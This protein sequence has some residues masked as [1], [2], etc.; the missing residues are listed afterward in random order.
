MNA[1]DLEP[2]REIGQVISGS[3]TDGLMMKL[4]PEESV[5]DIRAGRFVVAEGK[6]NQFFSMITDVVLGTS[7]KGLL[8]NPPRRSDLLMQQV[9]AGAATFGTVKLR[10]MLMLPHEEANSPA[11]GELR[12]VKTIPGHFSPVRGA[13]ARCKPYLRR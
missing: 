7:V 11:D 10:P 2:G 5:E 6:K 3:L 1:K 4:N 13:T 8:D 9:L 12:P